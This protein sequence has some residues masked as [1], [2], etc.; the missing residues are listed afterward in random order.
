M[1]TYIFPYGGSSGKHDTWDSE[2]EV[3]LTDEEAA[4]LE[5]SAVKDYRYGLDEDLELEDIYDKVYD[6]I[7]AANKVMMIEDGRLKERREDWEED[8]RIEFDEDDDA[9]DSSDEFDEDV[10]TDDELIEEELGCVSI[11][12]PVELQN[13][14]KGK[15]E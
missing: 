1:K 7:F 13:L 12:Y 10:P 8:H 14:C 5:A 4:R 11:S 6:L 3:E 15:M 2:I 9:P